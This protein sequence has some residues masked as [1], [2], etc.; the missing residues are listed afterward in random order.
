[1]GFLETTLGL[2]I[3]IATVV[4]FLM[5]ILVASWYKKADSGQALIRSGIGGN[6]VSF[7]GIMAIPV[8]HKLEVM[9][10]TQQILLVDLSGTRGVF[11]QDSIRVDLKAQFTVCVNATERDVQLVAI[12][13]GAKRA[14]DPETIR[15]LFQASFEEAIKHVLA[16][17]EFLEIQSNMDRIKMMILQE[18]GGDLSGYSLMSMAIEYIQQTPLDQL[19]P[20]NILDAKGIARIKELNQGNEKK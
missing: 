11:T 18:I 17:I 3:T 20:H 10:I 9:D 4:L 8:F 19:D 7:S 1:M 12:N 13:I 6:K 14:S 5:L 2:V 16:H 15:D